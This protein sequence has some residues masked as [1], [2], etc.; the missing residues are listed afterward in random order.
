MNNCYDQF[1]KSLTTRDTWSFYYYSGWY[2]QHPI[3]PPKLIEGKSAKEVLCKLLLLPIDTSDYDIITERFTE[4][5]FAPANIYA[6]HGRI[7]N[8]DDLNTVCLSLLYDL[9]YYKVIDAHLYYHFKF[10]TNGLAPFLFR[11]RN[12]REIMESFRVNYRKALS[13]NCDRDSNSSELLKKLNNAFI[14]LGFGANGVDLHEMISF[15]FVEPVM[16]DKLKEVSRFTI[17][18]YKRA[19]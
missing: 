19:Y 8:R 11:G 15:N 10:M 17:N 9:Y 7:S 2:S 12:P 3:Q 1:I 4:S 5:L 18:K 6:P 13:P 14:S 16:L